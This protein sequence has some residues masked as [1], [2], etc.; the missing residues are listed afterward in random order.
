MGADGLRGLGAIFQKG[1]Y[2]AAQDEATS[3]VYGMPRA[4]AEAH[5]VRRVLP[6]SQVAGE[7]LHLTHM[8]PAGV[9]A[10]QV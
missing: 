1:G 2:T 7:I 10:A 9:P 4:C 6:L 8:E 5:I 3:T